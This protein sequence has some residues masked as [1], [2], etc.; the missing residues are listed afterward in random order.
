MIKNDV[1]PTLDELRRTIATAD[2]VLKNDVN[3]A[4]EELRRAIGTANTVLRSADATLL[5]RDAP[6]PNELREALLEVT[7]AARS[8]SALT[9]FL[10]R[11][12]ES[13]IRGKGPEK[14]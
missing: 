1:N 6:F 14:R 10:E 13:L 2:G 7:R 5:G 9:D 11:H 8:L 12:P 4:L 3:A